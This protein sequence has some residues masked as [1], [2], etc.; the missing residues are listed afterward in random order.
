MLMPASS[1]FITLC[2]SQIGLLTHSLGASLSIV[3][4][5]EEL[6]EV[7]D[8]KLIPIAVYPDA[9][10]DWG[11]EQILAL[12]VQGHRA[13][14][15]RPLL[16]SDSTVDA[17]ALS[18]LPNYAVEVDAIPLQAAEQALLRQQQIVL[19]LM[20]EDV[21]MGLL[22]TA[23]ADRAWT[24]SE[25]E[26]IEQ[27]ANT[28]ALACVLDQRSQWLVQDAQRQRQLREQRH[29]LFDNLLHQF[30]N[31]L[32]ALRT[33]GKLLAKRLKPG[34]ANRTAAESIVRE[35]ERLQELLQYFDAA[36]DLD[37]RGLPVLEEGDPFAREKTTVESPSGLSR[38]A[39]PPLLPGAP[40]FVDTPL[41][42]IFL[43]ITEVLNP[44]LDLAIAIAQD[45]HLTVVT[46]IPAD[47]P[48]VQMDRRALREVLNNLIDNA[49]KYTP[50]GGQILVRVCSQPLVDRVNQQA[51]VIA[52]SGPGI[53]LQDLGH[54]FERH[55]RGIQATSNIPGTGLGL[56]IARDLVQQMQG[57]IQVFSPAYTSG[58]LPSRLSHSPGT[59]VVVWLKEQSSR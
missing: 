18:P 22:V 7:A 2:R 35:T 55:Y 23:R 33:F 52:D 32:T 13:P 19:P 51:V 27:I 17:S 56:A 10:M 3:Y 48:A 21:V 12:L 16:A 37:E 58:L 9:V 49:L 38:S 34:D 5:T 45:R 36:I 47:L 28:L 43:P 40:L 42:L 59:A 44:L 26:Q 4:L 20:H 39:S 14:I 31:P 41:Q 50:K 30:R 15:Q 29:D 57:E 1:E 53:P 6:S 25:T 8:A 11:E 24:E 46:D 54:L